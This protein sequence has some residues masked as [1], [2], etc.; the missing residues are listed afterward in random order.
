MILEAM[1]SGMTPSNPY[2]TAMATC[3]FSVLLLGLIRSKTP[4][5]YPIWPTPHFSAKRWA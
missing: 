1:A 5:T 2:P 4:L 3:P